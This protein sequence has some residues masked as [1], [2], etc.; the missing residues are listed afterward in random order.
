MREEP[1]K[2][3]EYRQ[4]QGLQFTAKTVKA[5]NIVKAELCS[6]DCFLHL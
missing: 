3:Q 1:P 2:N 5:H 6:T 4:K